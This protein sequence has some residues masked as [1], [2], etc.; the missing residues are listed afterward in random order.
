[1]NKAFFLTSGPPVPVVGARRIR[2][3]QIITALAKIMPVEVLCIAESSDLP[4]IQEQANAFFGPNVQVSC[5]SW[6]PPGLASKAINIIRPDF[7][8]NYS[9]SIEHY[10]K[11]RAQPGDLLWL[12]R[13]RM[14]KYLGLGHK[15]GCHT[16][17]DE[18]QVESDVLFDNAFTKVKYWHQGLTAAQCAIY[19]KKL[20]YEAEIV[21]TSSEID[22]ARMGKLAPRSKIKVIPHAIPTALYELPQTTPPVE[23]KQILFFGDFD[24]RPNQQALEWFTDE[25]LPRLQANMPE[26]CPEIAVASSTE[27]SKNKIEN[28]DS[29]IHFYHYESTEELLDIFNRSI[30]VVFP[31]RYGRGNR[32]N[33]LEALS[34]GMP[35]VSTGRGVDGLVLKPS[36]DICIAEEE[37]AFASFVLKVIR[38]SGYRQSLSTHA[39]Q[40]ARELYDWKET[41][42][43]IKRVLAEW[44]SF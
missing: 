18:H 44:I 15:L 9:D 1:M 10:L 12:S 3:A 20:C 25:I 38:D 39:K 33:V 32:I 8:Q 36:Y 11:S 37:D 4:P 2:D 19:E 41:D 31:L 40:T 6:N 27:E 17:L 23:K 26:K 35:I 28:L 16:I 7:A 24:Y 21:V 14:A 43:A 22:A 30:V 29:H 42:G 5:H 13:L 34:A